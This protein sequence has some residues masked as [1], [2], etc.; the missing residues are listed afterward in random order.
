MV[1]GEIQVVIVAQPGEAQVAVGHVQRRA[2]APGCGGRKTLD[3]EAIGTQPNARRAGRRGRLGFP[4]RY[5]RQGC[6]RGRIP[7]ERVAGWPA[8]RKSW[9]VFTRKD[10]AT[11]WRRSCRRY[12]LSR[13]TPSPGAGACAGSRSPL[14]CAQRLRRAPGPDLS[15]IKFSPVRPSQ[16]WALAGRTERG[17]RRVGRICAILMGF[18]FCGGV[19]APGVLPGEAPAPTSCQKKTCQAQFRFERLP[20]A[21]S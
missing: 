15:G 1:V 10:C 4:G 8:G 7:D 20:F 21:S 18:P 3:G 2:G 12:S 19:I 13:S 5:G 6:L 9:K 14:A 11:Q 16:R 17:P